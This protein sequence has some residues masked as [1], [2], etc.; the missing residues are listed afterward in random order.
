MFPPDPFGRYVG[1][2][3]LLSMVWCISK[4][5]CHA[6]VADG[7]NYQKRKVL[8]S[9]V[10]YVPR[11]MIARPCSTLRRRPRLRPD[12]TV[13]ARWR[14]LFSSPHP[15][16]FVPIRSHGAKLLTTMWTGVDRGPIRRAARF[17]HPSYLCGWTLGSTWFFFNHLQCKFSLSHH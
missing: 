14:T 12:G 7:R 13:F 1:E 11:Q 17:L 9:L 3:E 15:M 10:E 16:H 4:T 2:S 5:L 6:Y 8:Q